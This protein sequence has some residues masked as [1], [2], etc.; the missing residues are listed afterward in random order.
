[1][2]PFKIG[3]YVMIR[4]NP[5]NISQIVGA[6]DDLS[7]RLVYM[8]KE[9]G[10]Y[11]SEDLKPVAYMNHQTLSNSLNSK[12]IILT[13]GAGYVG[14]ILARKLL[15]EQC[16]VICIDSLRF[17][18]SAL[19]DIWDHP[20][21]VMKKVDITDHAIVDEVINDAPHP[22]AI[23]HLAAIVGD[24]ACK[25]EP[26]LA[27]KT[28]LEASIHLVEKAVET[29][30]ERFV[31][32]STCSNYGK[33]A[34]T[35][36]YVNEDSPLT[37]VSLYAELKVAVEDFILNKMKKTDSFSPTCL[38]F[39]TVYGISPRMR[40]DLTVNE[41]TKELALGRELVIFGEQF[42]RPYCYVGDFSRAIIAVLKQPKHK[43]AYNVFNVGDTLQNYT[44]KMLADELLKL[45]PEGT[46]KYVKREEDPRDYRV[47]FDKIKNE[48]EFSISKT[49]PEGMDDI[50]KSIRLGIIDDPDNQRYYNIPVKK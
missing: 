37:P 49:V 35:S 16:K 21:F 24:P 9:Q 27:R 11:F 18:G 23:I 43:V 6:A 19:V 7:G 29:K 20:N 44:K 50:L 34:E 48:L 42:W 25:L 26:E 10:T 31:F 40:F 8:V 13:G 5:N 28:N 1:M 45:I 4:N 15:Q 46:V 17:G 3:D 14:S 30:I 47:R 12:T 39:A 41:F 22:Y 33:M 38:R 2:I 32:A 36:G